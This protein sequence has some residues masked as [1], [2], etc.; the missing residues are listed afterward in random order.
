MMMEATHDP[1]PR[2]RLPAAAKTAGEV[3]QATARLAPQVPR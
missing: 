2:S 3:E 1:R